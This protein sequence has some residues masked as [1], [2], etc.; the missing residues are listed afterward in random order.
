MEEDRNPSLEDLKETLHAYRNLV[1]SPAWVQLVENVRAQLDEQVGILIRKPLQGM[2]EVLNEQYSKGK[3]AG[4][5]EVLD[6]VPLLMEQIEY[7][8]KQREGDDAE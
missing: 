7:E 2:D 1:K 6:T 4:A 3:I 8:I 5:E